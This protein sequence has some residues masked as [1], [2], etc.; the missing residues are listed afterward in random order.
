MYLL[1]GPHGITFSTDVDAI[2]GNPIALNIQPT[3]DS[4]PL[5]IW[6]DNR[7][8]PSALAPHP[9]SGFATA[10][11]D[12]GTL[13]VQ[14]SH[15]P[16]S[17]LIRNGVP[18]SDQATM[19]IYLSRHGDLLS[20][21]GAF[22]DPV[23]LTEPYLI[24]QVLK[25]DPSSNAG[26]SPAWRQSPCTPEIDVPDYSHDQVPSYLPGQNPS[27]SEMTALYHIPLEGVLGGAQTMYP[28]FLATMVAK[29]Y[30]PPASYCKQ[31][32]CGWIGGAAPSKSL[33]CPKASGE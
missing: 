6:L 5:K 26:S 7:A 30:R 24:S 1:N 18:N 23:Y 19:T 33:L 9:A 20:M 21:T 22:V 25:L 14:I 13:V 32:C 12:R 11:W 17:Y 3:I 15:L 27:I 10:H 8:E 29:G 31:Y 28:E 16:E 4:A 2:S